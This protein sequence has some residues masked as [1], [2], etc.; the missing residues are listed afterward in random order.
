MPGNAG[1]PPVLNSSLML[2]H[3]TL[4]ELAGKHT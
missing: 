3:G 1:N 4:Q 2:I